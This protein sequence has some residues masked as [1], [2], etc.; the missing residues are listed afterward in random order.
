MK[1]IM[2]V[3]AVLLAAMGAFA[4]DVEIV[5]VKGRG[6]GTDKTEALKDA[7]RDAVEQ[8]VGMYVDAEQMIK[9]EELVKDQI[10]TQSNAYIEKYEVAKETTKPNGLVEVQ[11]LA[12]V[13]KRELTRKISDVMPEKKYVLSNGLKDTHAKQ[14]TLEKRDM[15]GGAL[16]EKALNNI[17]NPF[18]KCIDCSLAGNDGVVGK[19]DETRD[20]C[21]HNEVRVNYLFRFKIDQKRYFE[22]V[23]MPLKEVLDQIAVSEPEAVSLP[24][25]VKSSCNIAE[26]MS[27][28]RRA[29]NGDVSAKRAVSQLMHGK[30]DDAA[31]IS[32]PNLYRSGVRAPW[33]ILLVTGVNKY[34]TVYTGSIYEIA[35][36]AAKALSEWTKRM[37][38]SCSFTVH[39]TDDEGEVV[40]T[41]DIGFKSLDNDQ[42]YGVLKFVPWLRG[43][44]YRDSAVLGIYRWESFE[45]PQKLLPEIKDMKIEIV[46]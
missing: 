39:F 12:E 2:I 26:S 38:N 13:R 8:A 9:D 5:K 44:W 25:S 21:G 32:L 7:Y 10:L 31:M 33:K 36:D 17:G 43:Y 45:I 6:V 3:A 16:I 19:I 27:L 18:L 23:A 29:A 46:K 4:Q 15:D 24:S 34:G 35:G 37:R 11:I 40:M 14:T 30:C 22:N 28:A 1:L 20:S 42:G 41:R